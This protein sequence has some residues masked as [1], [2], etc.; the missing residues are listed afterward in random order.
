MS[1]RVLIT[2]DNDLLRASLSALLALRG[3]P[4]FIVVGEAN[5]GDQAIAMIPQ[6]LPDVVLMDIAM[7]G[8]DG[9]EATTQIAEA[10]PKL[11]V[12]ILSSHGD[13]SSVDRAIQSGV[14]GYLLK[15]ASPETLQSA[16]RTVAGGDTYFSREVFTSLA[17]LLDRGAA[18]RSRLATLTPRHREVFR[19]I[20]EGLSSKEIAFQIGL[21]SKTIDAHRA[22]LMR[23]LNVSTIAE[24]VKIAIVE[25]L[26]RVPYP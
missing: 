9:I 21:S 10:Y 23:R 3:A 24:L 17:G 11:K 12:I 15:T 19:L 8:M 7:P 22:E 26:V 18:V 25:G 16:L 20:A 2:E 4:E 13:G 5:S 6:V 14:R 1:V